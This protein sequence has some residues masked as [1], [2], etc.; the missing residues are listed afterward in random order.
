MKIFLIKEDQENWAC[1]H[2]YTGEAEGPNRSPQGRFIINNIIVIIIIVLILSYLPFFSYIS[3][4]DT[5]SSSFSYFWSE[6]LQIMFSF[7]FHQFLIYRCL[8]ITIAPFLGT[9]AHH[10]LEWASAIVNSSWD[11]EYSLQTSGLF[12]LF[13]LFWYYYLNYSSFNSST[14]TN[15][16][17]LHQIRVPGQCDGA[18]KFGFLHRE[19]LQLF[20]EPSGI[21]GQISVR[22]YASAIR[23]KPFL[24]PWFDSTFNLTLRSWRYFAFLCYKMQDVNDDRHFK[25][26]FADY[27]STNITKSE[28]LHKLLFQI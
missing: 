24:L 19:R 6:F 2:G 21:C 8:T 3:A 28:V 26:P 14:Q 11:F 7:S 16:V 23:Q 20:F 22:I 12:G 15:E 5:I 17:L 9:S 13:I 18:R 1:S 10:Q 25:N 4:P 27:H